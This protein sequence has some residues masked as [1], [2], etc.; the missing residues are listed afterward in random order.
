[1]LQA[2]DLLNGAVARDPSFYAA[3]CELVYAHDQLYAV[4]GDH[5]PERR[6]A[7]EAA[8]ERATA[9]R[10]HAPETHLARGAHLYRAFHDYKGALSE[11]DAARA[12]LPNDPRIPELTGYILRRQG[13]QEERL[14]GL[15]QAVALDPRNP[16]LL[17]Q[18]AF[19]YQ[20][21]RRYPEEK[22]T[23]QRV[24]EITPED[25]GVAS[26]IAFADFLW[27][28]DTAPFHRLVDRLRAD[29]PAA[30]GDARR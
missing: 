11:L 28:A 9:L 20:D 26:N 27:R 21:L 16:R 6:A 29:R 12:G 13:K 7:A 18:L 2:I 3:F 15:E 24:L 23:F 30:M 4:F 22:A 17:S 14:R 10:P 8:L 5:T 25:V 1:M 19:S